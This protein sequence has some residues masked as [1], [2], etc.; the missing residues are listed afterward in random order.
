MFSSLF[1]LMSLA[2]NNGKSIKCISLTAMGENGHLK[3]SLLEKTTALPQMN[4]VND[5]IREWICMNFNIVD[6]IIFVELF[7]HKSVKNCIF[8]CKSHLD[9]L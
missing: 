4:R 1:T 6:N 2:L 9:F 8:N 3:N 7:L 5:K